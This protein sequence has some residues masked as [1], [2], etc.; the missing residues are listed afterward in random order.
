[1][2]EYCATA[3][4]KSFQLSIFKSKFAAIYE[5]RHH[6]KLYPV[7]GWPSLYCCILLCTSR[8][9][10]VPGTGYPWYVILAL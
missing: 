2:Q 8:C 6:K 3:V 7:F 9:T 10:A 5:I 1:M 4:I